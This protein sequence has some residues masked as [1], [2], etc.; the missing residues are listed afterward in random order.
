MRTSFEGWEFRTSLR[1]YVP[2]VGCDVPLVS[3]GVLNADAAVPVSLVGR[4][5]HGNPTGSYR[6]LV[7][8]VHIGNIQI[9]HGRHRLVGT[10][11]LTQLDHGIANSD[12][13][14]MDHAVRRGI[15]RHF[16]GAKGTFEEVD[17]RFASQGVQE[18]SDGVHPLGNV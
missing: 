16:F 10:M 12:G 4:F 17:Y 13:R 6:P 1:L 11:G 14:V 18:R 9:E 7:Q 15:S 8:S 3:E 2:Y 5:A